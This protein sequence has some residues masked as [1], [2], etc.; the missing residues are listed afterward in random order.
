MN[1]KPILQ[2]NIFL[3][4]FYY[5]IYIYKIHG[6][7]QGTTMFWFTYSQTLQNNANFAK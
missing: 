1:W 3:S 6:L 2:G 5:G 4:I 7:G